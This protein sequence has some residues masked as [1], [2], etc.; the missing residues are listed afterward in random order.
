M[1]F[2]IGKIFIYLVVAGLVGA[3]A[4]WL[5]R[6][7]Q[8][9]RA[10]ESAQRAAHDAKAKLPQLESLLRGR[11][12]QVSKLKAM[13]TE[14]K[15]ELAAYEQ[16][17]RDMEQQMREL[18]REAR[19]W[20]ERAEARQGHDLHDMDMQGDGT[21]D[22]DGLIAEL[23]REITRLKDEL[24]A[25]GAGA[26][27]TQADHLQV[28][29]TAEVEQL[30]ARLDEAERQLELAKA[31]LLDEQNKVLELEREREL[32]NKSLQVLYQQLE[33]ERT[34]RAANG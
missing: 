18:E 31:D 9:Q 1:I 30:R 28:M 11:D 25:A 15:A 33:L 5:V 6:N 7:L 26:G 23:S 27:L 17:M 2:L 29:G 22:A 8:A 4:G 13:L 19:R 21:G 3:L 24:A 16:K 34:R 32:Q 10:E 12:E 20:Q 14:K